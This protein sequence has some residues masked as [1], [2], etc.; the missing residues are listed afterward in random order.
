MKKFLLLY[1]L[2]SIILPAAAQDKGN[3]N[4]I[5]PEGANRYYCWTGLEVSGDTMYMLRGTEKKLFLMYSYDHGKSW[6]NEVIDDLASYGPGGDVYDVD[7]NNKDSK[8]KDKTVK[9]TIDTR[10]AS[11]GGW[12]IGFRMDKK[13]ALHA[14]Y[15]VSYNNTRMK[16]WLKYAVKQPGGKWSVRDVDMSDVVSVTGYIGIESELAIDSKG[17]IHIVYINDQK[18]MYAFSSDG[19]NWKKQ[20]IAARRPPGKDPLIDNEMKVNASGSEVVSFGTGISGVGIAIDSKDGIHICGSRTHDHLWYCYSNNNGDSWD[21]EM[22]ESGMVTTL[23]FECDIMTDNEDRPHVAM[24]DLHKATI[25]GVKENGKWK[26]TKAVDYGCRGNLFCDPDG[27]IHMTTY[28][29]YHTLG[30]DNLYFNY[31]VSNDNGDTWTTEEIRTDVKNICSASFADIAF[32]NSRIYINYFTSDT[33]L[34]IAWKELKLKK[35]KPKPVT[36]VQD[37]IHKDTASV[38]VVV[39]D[40]ASVLPPDLTIKPLPRK[41]NIAKTI[42]SPTED[43]ELQIYDHEKQDGDRISIQFNGQWILKDHL[44]TNEKHTLKLKLVKGSQNLLVVYAINLGTVPPN[45]STVLITGNNLNEQVTL[46]SD[47]KQSAAIKFVF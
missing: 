33:G 39:K 27:N 46:E 29:H 5:N 17:N 18:L 38:P 36:V 10:Y 1:L 20:Q 25:H 7:I 45:T 41:V 31:S 11:V 21:I 23:W 15:T 9:G 3:W 8:A 22:L 24:R 47:M 32:S 30:Q 28:P 16:S 42:Y 44:L 43:V 19:I 40:S 14:C 2:A 4:F 26:Y 12:N 34:A 6:K 35:K 13:G 37:N